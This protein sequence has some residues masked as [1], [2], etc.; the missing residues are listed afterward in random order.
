MVLQQNVC[1][2]FEACSPSTEQN[3]LSTFKT[4]VYCRRY[5]LREWI[6]IFSRSKNLPTFGVSDVDIC[7]NKKILQ[8]LCFRRKGM[9]E[10]SVLLA[11]AT[12]AH[13]ARWKIEYA[14]KM[15]RLVSRD[16]VLDSQMIDSPASFKHM[17]YLLL[18][19][20]ENQE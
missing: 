3:A 20:W 8:K 12:R 10:A 2:Y 13:H 1:L 16:T 11:T 15:R 6:F 14:F 5:F 4:R 17:R 9:V 18:K 7:I 19:N